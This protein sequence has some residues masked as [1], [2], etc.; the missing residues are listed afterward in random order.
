VENYRLTEN[1]EQEDIEPIK[2][3]DVIRNP[4]RIPLEVYCK[5]LLELK[6]NEA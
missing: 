3:A 6:G 5:V 1:K 2:V 4:C